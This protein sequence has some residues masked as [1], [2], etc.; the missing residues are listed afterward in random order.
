[1]KF[2]KQV[3]G[4]MD[5]LRFKKL[6]PNRREAL[7]SGPDTPL[8]KVYRTNQQAERHHTDYME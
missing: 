3:F 4:F 5:M 7:A 2:K 1:M 8:P 6:V